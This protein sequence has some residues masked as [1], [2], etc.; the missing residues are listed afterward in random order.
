MPSPR[1][2]ILVPAGALGLG[3]DAAA[4]RAGIE[5]GPDLIAIDGGSTDSGPSYLGRGVSK[6]SR[7]RTKADWAELVAARA[8]AG[9]PLVIGTAGTCGAGPAVD[10]LLDITREILAERGERARIATLHCDRDPAALARDWD[11]TRALD[12]APDVAAAD[13]AACSHVVALAG[14]EQVGAALATGAEIVICGRAT[15]TAILAALPI[16]RGADPGAAW[17]GAK[18][19]EC[20]ALCTTHPW[21]GAIL[22][23]VEGDVF[24][25]TPLASGARATPRSVAAHML[26]ENADPIR[27]HEPGG[28]LDVAAARYEALGGRR[29][30]VSGGVWHPAP[31]A[32]KLEGARPSG[33]GAASLAVIRDEAVLADLDRWC[34]TLLAAARERLGAHE[35]E[36]ALLRMGR[37]AVLGDVEPKGGPPGEAGILLKVRAATEAAAMEAAR[38]VNPLLLHHSADPDEPMPTFAFPLSPPEMPL[39]AQHEFVLH[40]VLPLDDPMDGFRLAVHDA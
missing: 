39:G 37:D 34:D 36:L 31:Y 25:I 28:W 22:F 35:A 27:L 18:V 14:V 26:Y 10:W 2:R 1:T 21:S 11:R 40:H 29:V 6:Y 20:G 9:C 16:R 15:D 5:A 13:V 7:A 8:E 24:E 33:F 38:I 30:R 4:L 12:G 32:V 23:D 3:W 19:A 17:H